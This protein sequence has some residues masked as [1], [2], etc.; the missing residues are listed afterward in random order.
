MHVC[1]TCSTSPQVLAGMEAVT[2]KHVF[3]EFSL[4]KHQAKPSCHPFFYISSERKLYI[5]W[6][7]AKEY[8]N[9]FLHPV[10]G[11]V[12]LSVFHRTT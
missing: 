8:V 7:S 3:R 10:T 1:E 12:G 9:A 2:L 5:D 4:L 6:L 11:Q